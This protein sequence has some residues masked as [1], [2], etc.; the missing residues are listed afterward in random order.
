MPYDLPLE[1][2]DMVGVRPTQ[3]TFGIHAAQVIAP[4]DPF[5]SVL[6]YRMLKLG[7]GRMPHIG[8]TEV[9]RAGVELIYDWIRQMPQ[10]AA[11]DTAGNQTAAKLRS[12]E[13]SDLQRLCEATDASPEQAELTDHLLSST[14]GALLLLRSVDSRTLPPPAVSLAIERATR[15]D[16]PSVRD[17]F[18]RFLP[19]EKR[20]KRLGSVIQPRQILSLPG[21]LAR[22]KQVFF[23]T[24]GVQCKNCHRI[25][26][27]GAE[28]GPDLTMIGKKYNRAQ[29]L[30]SMLDPSKLIDPN[31][32]TYLAE[33]DD[34][35]LLTGLLVRKDVDEVV[36]KDAQNEVIR[37]PAGEIQRFVP[38]QLSLMPDL[39]LRDMTAQQVAD[40]LAYLSSLK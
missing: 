12:E 29:L 33:T 6:W 27:D 32:V 10:D 8:S 39:L 21:D 35:R 40:L 2:T 13:A 18:E 36:L 25:Q 1:K 19:A 34:G 31:Y 16:D 4:G 11:K 30:E 38:Q 24:D 37:I 17:L 3:G 5:R 26:Q 9:D 14:S 7:G 15:H 28:V 22:G 23:S 20:I